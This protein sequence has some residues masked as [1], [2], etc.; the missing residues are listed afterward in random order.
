M[1]SYG[2]VQDYKTY[3]PESLRVFRGLIAITSKSKL[4][5]FSG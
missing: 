4:F 3:V 2:T 5:A 1:P